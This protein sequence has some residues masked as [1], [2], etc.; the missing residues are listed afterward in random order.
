M[1]SAPFAAGP[2]SNIVPRC[3][4]HVA[5]LCHSSSLTNKNQKSEECHVDRF[6]SPGRGQGDPR[7]S[8]QMGAGGMHPGGKGTRQQAARRGAGPAVQEDARAGLVV[9]VLA[10]G[11]WRV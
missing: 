6:R 10:E 5:A 9:P 1:M 8:P 3:R 11:I 2:A 4:R 7:E